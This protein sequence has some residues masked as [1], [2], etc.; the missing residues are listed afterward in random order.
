VL[1][2]L[3]AAYSRD[4]P[5]LIIIEIILFG[6]IF[7]VIGV[8]GVRA[9]SIGLTALLIYIINV[10]QPK[11]SGEWLL[12][13]Y[14]VAGGIWYTLL[15]LALYSI[16]PYRPTQQMLGECMMEIA[17]YLQTKELFYEDRRNTSSIYQQLMQFQVKIHNHFDQL[18][19]MLYSTRKFLSESTVRGRVTM[20]MFLETA[21]LMERIMTSQQDYE[22]LHKE[23]DDAGILK[24]YGDLI[25]LLANE[26][27]NIG[28]A[29]QSNV[30]YTSVD[31]I[32][33]AL[34]ETTQVFFAL[35]EQKLTAENIESFIRLRQI[36]YS[37]Q[38]LTERIKR[39]STYTTY[40]KRISKQYKED[41]EFDKFI[42]P[43]QVNLR[44]L[45]SNISFKSAIFRHAVRLVI[46]LLAGYIISLLFPLGHGY[47]IMLTTAVILKPAY[48]LS[49]Q[50]NIRRVIGTL[51]GVALGFTILY[52]TTGNGPLFI[53]ML[54]AMII[55][56]SFLKLNYTIAS[57]GITVFVILNFH[58][59]S[60]GSIQP[61]LRDRALDTVI[62]SVIAYLVSHFVLPTWEH[63]RI[64]EYML[65][66]IKTNQNYFNVVAT[67]FIESPF[68]L[69]NYKL[70]RKEAFVALANLSDNFQRMISEPKSQQ[71][72]MT[73]FHQFVAA[74]HMLTSYIASIAYYAQRKSSIRG[75]EAFKLMIQHGNQLFETAKLVIEKNE[76]VSSLPSALPVPEEVNELL[77]K[78]RQDIASGINSGSLEV[79]KRLSDLKTIV[80]QYQLVY[81]NLQEQIKILQQIKGIKSPS[82][83]KVEQN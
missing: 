26:L 9:N 19:Q 31:H 81:S 15:S 72:H 61:L 65:D 2:L 5:V 47:W 39:L 25:R 13:A 35:R 49:R 79:R 6:L 12:A 3:V 53:I 18:R 64:E 78:R 68:N 55:G 41:V 76:A 57:A 59:L 21:D 20:M 43:E 52:L 46:G 10:D 69:T 40:D 75:G 60:P 80:E 24:K 32:E 37:L 42:S 44:L 82:L 36:L 33:V 11:T 17:D 27:K 14:F 58:F 48:S 1:S 16:R 71:H 70:A 29:V 38:D 77:Q 63:E 74:T 54:L 34:N 51:I 8:F 23:F 56:Y 62:G 66:A 50:R 22:L 7:T 73:E 28:L 30:S 45:Q 4:H 83:K 67:A